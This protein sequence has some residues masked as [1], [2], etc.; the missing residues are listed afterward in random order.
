MSRHD[1]GLAPVIAHINYSPG[2]GIDHKVRAEAAAAQS[3]GIPLHF[4]LMNQPADLDEGNYHCRPGNEGRTGPFRYA[5]N[6]VRKLRALEPILAAH[7]G[8]ILR[9]PKVPF[10]Y[11]LVFARHGRR[12]VT[13]HHTD[14]VGELRTGRSLRR[15]VLSWLVTLAS[16]W[17][18]QR[19][20]GIIAITDELRLVE[21]RKAGPKPSRTIGNGVR[22]EDIEPTGFRPFDGRSLNLVLVASWIQPW[23]GLDRLLA[24]LRAYDGDVEVTLDVVGEVDQGIRREAEQINLGGKARVTLSGPRYGRELDARFGPATVAVASLALHRNRMYQG[25]TLK[26]REYMARGI[27]FVLGYQ[28]PDLEG[29][30]EYVLS[31]PADETAL[32]IRL[33]VDFARRVSVDP[34]TLSGRMRR[35]ALE[36]LDWSAKVREMYEFAA[37]AT[38]GPQHGGRRPRIPPQV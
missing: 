31:V 23:H 10:S 37:R 26:V 7:D 34:K 12:L 20:A 22:V 5:L 18:L 15:R 11:V 21:L 38:A 8:A 36:K 28:D 19:S 14:E 33:I 25:S 2:G 32:D 1:A 29:A 27:P 9:F 4:Y 30:G 6:N 3:S 35:F 24:G 13:E 17:I 16:G